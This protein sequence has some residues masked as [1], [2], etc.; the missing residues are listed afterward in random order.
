MELHAL[1]STPRRRKARLCSPSE[2]VLVMA[3]SFSRVWLADGLACKTRELKGVLTC[4]LLCRVHAASLQRELVI[5]VMWY[6]ARNGVHVTH[7]KQ[8]EPYRDHFDAA[9]AESEDLRRCEDDDCE[10]DD[11]MVASTR[12]WRLWPLTSTSSTRS[13]PTWTRPRASRLSFRPW[14][15]ACWVGSFSVGSSL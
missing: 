4:A 15:T 3:G 6:T 1:H 10:D 12:A 7:A 2:G 11:V 13:S 5:K 14:C 8:L 9:V